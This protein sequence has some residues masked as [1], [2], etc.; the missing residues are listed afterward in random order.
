[1]I[2]SRSTIKRDWLTPEHPMGNTFN[3]SFPDSE[4]SARSGIDSARGSPA[5]AAAAAAGGGA[6]GGG[7]SFFGSGS[8]GGGAAASDIKT[9]EGAPL[10][11]AIS[12]SSATN[13][14]ASART[15]Y[16]PAVSVLN[17]TVPF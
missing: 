4:R 7:G 9:G 2:A 11:T 16:V 6:G 1:G 17:D 10:F 14:L 15:L 13:P 8:G 3:G 5:G 12:F